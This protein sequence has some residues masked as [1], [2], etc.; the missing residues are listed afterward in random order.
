VFNFFVVCSI[1]MVAAS[2]VLEILPE[3]YGYVI[4]VA[5]DSIFLN[6]WLAVNVGKARKQHHIE[7]S[8][9]LQFL[10]Y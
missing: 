5:V 8:I 4:F 3:G 6:M 10:F 7:V 9:K 1:T 2:K